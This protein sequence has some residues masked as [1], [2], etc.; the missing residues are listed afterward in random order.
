MCDA[1]LQCDNVVSLLTTGMAEEPA[2]DAIVGETFAEIIGEQFK[3]LKYGDRFW[4][5]TSDPVTGF[6]D[7]KSC[8]SS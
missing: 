2:H 3:R 5:E 1:Y 4:H 6:T 7:S 8:R